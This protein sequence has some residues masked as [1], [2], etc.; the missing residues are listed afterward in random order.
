MELKIVKSPI[1]EKIKENEKREV[2]QKII[3]SKGKSVRTLK[4]LWTPKPSKITKM[5]II[6]K[7]FPKHSARVRRWTGINRLIDQKLSTK[8]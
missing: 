7:H 6:W 5:K 4:R 3:H 2:S 1:K 8:T